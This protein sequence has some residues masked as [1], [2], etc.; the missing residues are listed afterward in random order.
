MKPDAE[1]H[2]IIVDSMKEG[3]G[4]RIYTSGN[5]RG[6]LWSDPGSHFENH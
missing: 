2:P 4:L 1:S 3:Y 6:F 5:S